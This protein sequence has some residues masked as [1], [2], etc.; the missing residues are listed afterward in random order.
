[1]LTNSSHRRMSNNN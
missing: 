1:M